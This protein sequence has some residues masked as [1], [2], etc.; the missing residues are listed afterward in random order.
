MNKSI[1]I[2]SFV[3]IGAII[4]LAGIYFIGYKNL[5]SEYQQTYQ[6]CLQDLPYTQQIN[7]SP[8]QNL[9]QQCIDNGGC[10]LGCG[11]ACEPY[12]SSGYTFSET[13]YSLVPAGCNK[14]CKSVC[15]YP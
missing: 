14:M 8:F 3:S 2:I 5:K 12:K 7:N 6:K 11:S 13:F 15:L 1:K 9:A 10:Y 4:I